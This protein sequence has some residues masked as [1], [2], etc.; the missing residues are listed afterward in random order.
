MYL[1]VI[2]GDIMKESC[3][4]LVNPAN[5]T[6]AHGGGLCGTIFE[7]IRQSSPQN[8]IALLT[9][10]TQFPADRN[11]V[12][13]QPGQALITNAPGLQAKALIHTV[14]AQ[15]NVHNREQQRKIITQC[16]LE[17]MKLANKNKFKSI[18]FPLIGAGIYGCSK[19]LVAKCLID[20]CQE[21]LLRKNC[22]LTTVK[23]VVQEPEDMDLL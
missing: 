23:L 7:A 2:L 22:E 20:A 17:S 18:A 11:G 13:C 3:D 12:R 9:E 15:K 4:V 5:P 8:Y 6:L 14:G 1:R 19:K 21:M 16:Y 10:L